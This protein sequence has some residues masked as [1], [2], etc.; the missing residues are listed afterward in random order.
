MW[1]LL[2]FPLVATGTAV[3]FA[4]GVSVTLSI[5]GVCYGPVGSFLPE[6]FAPQHRYTG[7]GL[8]YNIAG[9]V[10]GAL[11][12][13]IAP[14]L[15]AS[16]GGIG[17]GIMLSTLAVLSLACTLGLRETRGVPLAHHA[18]AGVRSRAQI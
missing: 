12:P 2:L 11:P 10:G 5:V 13:L 8:A 4:I 9:I 17:I 14:A 1:G 16:F 6:L 15:V 7:A 3:S 18:S